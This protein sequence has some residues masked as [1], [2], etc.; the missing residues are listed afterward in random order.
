MKKRE[1]EANQ[2]GSTY[3]ENGTNEVS[4]QIMDAYNSGVIDHAQGQA[5]E[6]GNENNY[7]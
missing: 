5:T 1:P 4:Q 6:Q 7:Q 3:D 2:Y